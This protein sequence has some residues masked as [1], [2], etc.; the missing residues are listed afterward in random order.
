MIKLHIKTI[1][2]LFLLGFLT[3]IFFLSIELV[4]ASFKLFGK[5]VAKSLI[6]ITSNPFI[7][8]FI[9]ILATSIVQS[10][11]FTTS[12]TVGMVASGVLSLRNAIPIIMGANIGTTITNTLVSLVHVTRKL[13]FQ[14]AYAGAVIHDF[15]NLIAVALLLPLELTIHFLEKLA[16]LL[17]ITFSSIGG[18]KIISP[19]K[20]ITKP[21]LE[22]I[23]VTINY[24]I[25]LSLLSFFMLFLS[26]LFMVKILRNLV[27][28]KFEIFMDK[29]LF[30]TPLLSFFLGLIFTAIVQSS[31]VTT[32]L[33]IPLVGAGILSVEKIFPYVLGANVGTTVTAMLASFVTLNPTAIA[34]AFTHLL[35]NIFGIVL[36]YPT[37]KLPIQLAKKFSVLVS[38]SKIIA[39][40]YILLTFFILPLILILLTKG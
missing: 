15:F 5:D 3:Y 6:S 27:T 29:Y 17:T 33:I 20:L 23:I 16:N 7:A 32:S 2:E 37:R 14:R 38:N 40:I 10:S 1:K 24:P 31:S 4:G 34:V 22:H 8:L 13:E 35:F 21:I 19:L 36:I 25:I 12:L 28:A 30:R 39:I 11:S 26:L 9:G 18:I